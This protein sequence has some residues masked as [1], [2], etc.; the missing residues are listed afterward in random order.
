[1]AVRY[2]NNYNNPENFKSKLY[3]INYEPMSVIDNY[4]TQGEIVIFGKRLLQYN[5]AIHQ[6]NVITTGALPDFELDLSLMV[7]GEDDLITIN[8]PDGRNSYFA[9]L[10]TTTAVPPL[11]TIF[12]QE[13]RTYF[14]VTIATS[15]TNRTSTIGKDIMDNPA[16]FILPTLRPKNFHLAGKVLTP[17]TD[18]TG[19]KLGLQI[20]YSV[21]ETR[22]Y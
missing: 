1:M 12:D 14:N 2:L 16:V 17:T 4:N 21:L 9:E 6:V 5:W 19:V 8:S 18:V 10:G 7:E 13:I 22:G 3:S 11:D 20:I 15:F